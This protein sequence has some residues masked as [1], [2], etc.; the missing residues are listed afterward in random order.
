[1]LDISLG[2]SQSFEISLL[3]IIYLDLYIFS[4]IIWFFDI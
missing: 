1:M 2:V 3:R 4:W